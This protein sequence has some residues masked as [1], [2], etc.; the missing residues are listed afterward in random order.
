MLLFEGISVAHNVCGISGQ[1]ELTRELNFD[2]GTLWDQLGWLDSQAVLCG[3]MSRLIVRC[4]QKLC[5]EA[6]S[7]LDT[8]IDLIRCQWIGTFREALLAVKVFCGLCSVTGE[9]GRPLHL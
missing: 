9:A 7:R 2:D 4:P 8:F 5:L 6:Y 3:L 1:A